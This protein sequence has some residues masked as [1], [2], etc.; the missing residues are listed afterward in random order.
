MDRVILHCDL[1]NFFA[2]VSLLY[3]QTL[4]NMPV[5]VCGRAEDRHGIVLAKNEIAKK[6]GV[7]TAEP[8]WQA[9]R[10]C[11]ELCILPPLYDKYEY[12]SNAVKNIYKRYTDKIEPFGIDECWLDVTGSTFLFGGGKEIGERIRKE[13]K[14]ELGLTISV[15]VSFNKIFAK[16]GSDMKK[17]DALCCITRENF[18][19]TVWNLPIEDLLFIGGS[20][21]KK[22]RS[23]GIFKIGDIALCNREIL[24]GFLGKN[25]ETI[26]NYALGLD[27]SEVIA[28]EKAPPPKSIGKSETPP[29]DYCNDNAIWVA[30]LS[31]SQD[32]AEQLR[33]HRLYAKGVQIS[34]RTPDLK[35][36]EYSIGLTSPS[37]S[38]II[39]AKTGMELYIKNKPDTCRSIG[40]RAI[41]LTKNING[42][43]TDMFDN[44]SLCA[45]EEKI[46]RK[47]S[48]INSRFGKNSVLRASLLLKGRL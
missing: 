22:L 21:S 1:N 29:K 39:L 25:G 45:R 34:V 31:Y 11:P 7:K 2:S 38:G 43:Q 10:K 6:F 20:T 40:I 3:N 24:K 32:I 16:L 13:V 35:T 23:L 41:N 18:K 4:T 33:H 36:R 28:E 47:L 42:I 30:L 48:E 19:D 26:Y 37:D 44:F 46:E 9:Q 27:N 12:Y 15:G 5:A 8:I 14:E 17:P